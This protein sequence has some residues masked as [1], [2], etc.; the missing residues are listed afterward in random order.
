MP[1][2]SDGIGLSL[3]T[4]GHRDLGVWVRRAVSAVAWSRCHLLCHWLQTTVTDADQLKLEKR[5]GI[6]IAGRSTTS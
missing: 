4:A 2:S 3:I 1:V 6:Q 5:A